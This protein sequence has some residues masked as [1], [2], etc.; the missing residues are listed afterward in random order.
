VASRGQIQIETVADTT[1]FAAKLQADLARI[2]S[3]VKVNPVTVDGDTDP[4]E[5]K[6]RQAAADVDK[7]FLGMYARIRAQASVAGGGI[8]TALGVAIKASLASAVGPA[9]SSVVALLASVGPAALATVPAAVAVFGTLKVALLGVGDALKNVGD[10]EKFNESLKSLSPNAVKFAKAIKGIL[11]DLAKVRSEVQNRFFANLDKDAKSVTK[12]LIGPLG[13]GMGKTADQ[14]N[15]I[16]RGVADFLA[17]SKGAA[18]VNAIFSITSVVLANIADLFRPLLD[19]LSDWLKKASDSGIN[20]AFMEA[21]E[22]LKSLAATAK[23]VSDAI[24]SVFGGLGKDGPSVAASLEKASAAVKN[25]L[26]SAEAQE[27]LK[28]LG[29]AMDRVRTIALKVLE[30]LPKLTPA[31]TALAEGAFKTLLDIVEKVATA[32]T[33]MGGSVSGQTALFTNLG[34]AIVLAI[35]GV[36]LYQAAV[37]AVT[38]AQ[39][40]WT[41]AVAATSVTVT[42]G[43]AVYNTARVALLLLSTGFTAAGVQATLLGSALW[44]QVTAM[45]AAA[46]GYARV[47]A[48]AVAAGATQ[49]ATLAAVSA[50][51]L[52]L[53]VRQALATLGLTLYATALR[54]GRV[55]V[56]AWTAAQWLLNAAMTAN[57]IGIIIVVI[58][59]LVAAIVLAYTKSET[60][61][62]IVDGALKAVGAAA[63]WLYENALKPL[64]AFWVWGFDLIVG[65]VKIWWS[66]V[67]AAFKFVV[68]AA[69]WLWGQIVATFNAIKTAFDTVVTKVSEFV[70]MVIGFFVSLGVAVVAKTNALISSVTSIPGKIMSSLGNLGNLL[71][72][73]GSKIV[74]GLIDGIDGMIQKLKNKVGQMTQGIRDFLPFSPAKVGA[75]SGSGAPERSGMRIV[76]G[77]ASGIDKRRALLRQAMAGMTADLAIAPPGINGAVRGGDGGAADAAPSGGLRVWPN[78]PPPDAAGLTL[79]S[80][81]SRIGDVLVEV[82]A[83]TVRVRGG[84][85]QKVLGKSQGGAQ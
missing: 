66:F 46:A 85:V 27:L 61:R 51:W 21:K 10:E 53:A 76:E 75:L 73:A 18:A 20:S 29:D 56:L 52:L 5:R 48:A 34:S 63:M 83:K 2:M 35:V 26:A 62:N 58:A 68:D 47:A 41:V 15:K 60:F 82:I 54:V 77:V 69:V 8:G 72:D 64:F 7:T 1:K 33:S 81:G 39:T 40:A 31:V 80:D 14:L 32:L 55:A 43:T 17:S 24:G 45:A 84:D 59:L 28:T 50:Q 19:R 6:V 30:D 49:V 12:T 71:K 23:N 4:L 13:A 37:V 3:T 22:T 74:Q 16:V 9:V 79:V 57:P 38:V 67:T 36:K 25:F 70:G 78:Q 65:A 44:A 42:A 11:P